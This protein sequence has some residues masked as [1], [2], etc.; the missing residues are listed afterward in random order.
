LQN[1]AVALFSNAARRALFRRSLPLYYTDVAL[2]R[3]RGRRDRFDRQNR[4]PRRQKKRRTAKFDVS[5]P[6]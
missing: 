5:K 2:F 3:Q 6:R 1:I 4:S